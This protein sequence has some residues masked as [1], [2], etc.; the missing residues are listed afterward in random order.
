MSQSSSH[1]PLE[2]A[3][4]AVRL[5]WT[6]SR[7]AIMTLDMP[8]KSANV[9]TA[10]MLD[11]LERALDVLDKERDL[12]G[13][14][15]RSA[16]PRIFVAG[17]DLVAIA[18]SLDW[19]DEAIVAFC[20]RGQTMFE[21]LRSYPAASVA[22]IDGACLGGGLELALACDYRIATNESRTV[23]GLPEVKLG[24]IPGWAGTVRL[25]RLV[26][27]EKAGELLT[28]GRTIS[29]TAAAEIGLVDEIVPSI[30]CSETAHRLLDRMFDSEEL[31]Q[32]RMKQRAPLIL[33]GSRMEHIQAAMEQ[34]METRTD[35]H[36]FAPRV[37]WEQ[38]ARAAPL[39]F[40][41]A[42]RAEGDAMC[43]VWG[44]PTCRGL[45]NVYF[46]GEHNKKNPGRVN[47]SLKPRAIE[48]VGIVGLGVMGVA[49][50]QVIADRV[51]SII[52]WDERAEARNR[53]TTA[54]QRDS[55][56]A[57]AQMADLSHC[58]LVIEAITEDVAAKQHVLAALSRLIGGDALLATNTST[59]PLQ[60]LGQDV[61]NPTRLVGIH[62][63]HPQL[64]SLVEIVRSTETDENVV[65]AAVQW[66]R[67]LGKSPVVV[68]D[69]PGFVVNRL[70]ASLFAVALNRVHQ[71]DDFESIDQGLRAFGF[72]AGPFEIMDI[73]GIDTVVSAG[74]ALAAAKVAGLIPSPLLPK[75]VRLGRLGRKSGCGFYKYSRSGGPAEHDR[76]VRQVI[77]RYQLAQSFPNERTAAEEIAAAMLMQACAILDENTVSD[78]RDIDWCAIQGLSFPPFRGGVLAWAD[79]EGIAIIGPL[80]QYMQHRYPEFP[81]GRTLE[82]WLAGA[83]PFYSMVQA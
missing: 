71:G 74:R 43:Q 35:L 15:I 23:L 77:A 27:L 9:L 52:G 80:V 6:D 26:G 47:L 38:I 2:L 73:I 64:M 60:T 13:L 39:D 48:R 45:L 59:I 56:T 17:A 82:A 66:V 4:T 20:R 7:M 81:S 31:R 29:A 61:S 11:D 51:S 76:D 75:L 62:F 14:V 46:L 24:L 79:Q 16:K 3:A 83:R 1:R 55:C 53:F 57:A 69:S 65:A 40:D 72:G 18:R 21:R 19:P 22:L 10:A 36:P 8:G 25:P 42:C 50:G 33:N 12:R 30:E 67:S 41:E 34:A 58:D 37:V 49:I 32:R 54:V 78:A 28:T 70:L 5:D 68:A 44:S 63:C